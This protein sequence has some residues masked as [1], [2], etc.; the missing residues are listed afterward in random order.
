MKI[1]VTFASDACENCGGR[2]LVVPLEYESPA[3]FVRDFDEQMK[4]FCEV[5][6]QYREAVWQWQKKI[7]AATET[8]TALRNWYEQ[9]PVKLPAENLKFGKYTLF[10]GDFLKEDADTRQL[11]YDLPAAHSVE[12]WF[13]R[14]EELVEK[15]HVNY[16][17]A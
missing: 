11:S 17:Y 7:P 16:W 2:P 6:Q 10:P 9:K 4:V 14:G 8:E 5:E 12:E 15:H 1:V 13:V 3:A